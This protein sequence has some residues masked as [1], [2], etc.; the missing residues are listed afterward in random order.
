L[1]RT[2]FGSRHSVGLSFTQDGLSLLEPPLL[3]AERTPEVVAVSGV[4]RESRG[5]VKTLPGIPQT[6]L[7]QT[8]TAVLTE[9]P[10]TP[11]KLTVHDA[12]KYYLDCIAQVA[13]PE[14]NLA[15]KLFST[16]CGQWFKILRC[17][18]GHR[19][20][21]PA[22]CRKPYCSICGDIEWHKT[23][24]RLYPKAQQMLPAAL[25]TIRSPNDCTLFEMNRHH[26]RRFIKTVITALKSLGYQRGIVFVHLFGDDKTKYAFHLHILLDG[27]WLDPEPLQELCSKLRRMIYPEWVVKRWGDKLDVNY[28]YKP[29]QGQVYQSLDYCSRPTFTQLEGNEWLADSIRG[30]R[31]VRVWGKWDEEPKWHLDESEKKVHNLV[32]LQKGKCPVCGEPMKGDKGIT[33]K[34]LIDFEG[35]TEIAPGYLLLQTERAPPKGRLDLS[36]LI[37]LPDGDYRKHSN[38]C[39]KE[40]DRHRELISRRHDYELA[41]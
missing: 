29:T 16:K 8:S 12:V 23:I 3:R 39:R 19:I 34:A 22:N 40:I 14:A 36:N 2:N 5:E 21:V 24:A 38:A 20:A 35:S 1:G 18:N 13:T 10:G 15:T 6:N 9:T 30:E 4:Y 17:K 32:A 25:L 33:P 26:R 31:K 11:Q 7:S 41:S 27:G 28:R 37:E